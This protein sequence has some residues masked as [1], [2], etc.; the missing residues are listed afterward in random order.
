MKR[1]HRPDL[2]GWSVFD[3]KRDIDFHGLL[4]VRDGG[5]VL[6]DPLPMSAHDAAHLQ[7]LGGATQVVAVAAADKLGTA[8]AFEVVPV[9]RLT[10]LVTD[11]TAKSAVLK[12]FKDAGLQVITA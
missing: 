1:L 5:N 8:G 4:W 12:A 6:V 11:R 10:H 2:F 3:E 7:R 9:D